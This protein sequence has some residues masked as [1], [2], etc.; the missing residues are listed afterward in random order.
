MAILQVRNC[1]IQC[2]MKHTTPMVTIFIAMTTPTSGWWRGSWQQIYKR[3]HDNIVITE[4]VETCGGML[5]YG[6]RSAMFT[7]L[8]RG[9]SPRL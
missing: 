6:L 8:I 4:V 1:Q 9:S 3:H 7:S 2:G 5:A